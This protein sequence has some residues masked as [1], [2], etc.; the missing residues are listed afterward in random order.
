MCML[1]FIGTNKELPKIPFNK[2]T[3][4]LNTAAITT[5]QRP[6]KKHFSF[7]YVTYIGSDQ[8]CGCGFQG[9][10]V[11]DEDMSAAMGIQASG[12]ENRASLV[13]FIREHLAD[14]THVEIYGCWAEDYDE[15][16]TYEAEITLQDILA[17]EFSFEERGLYSVKIGG[18]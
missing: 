1:F 8:K 17:K 12:P 3:P 10:P 2:A 18:K 14:H 9:G 15:E 5:D 7:P 16:K 13:E 6:V 11:Q 4:A